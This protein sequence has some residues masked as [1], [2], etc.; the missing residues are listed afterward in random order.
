LLKLSRSEQAKAFAE[1]ALRALAGLAG[2]LKVKY[3]RIAVVLP[4]VWL[5]KE[6]TPMTLAEAIYEHSKKLPED[7]AREVLDFIEFLEQ[8]YATRTEETALI[9]ENRRRAALAQLAGIRIDWGGK[10][11]ADRE[12]LHDHARD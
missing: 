10:P 12:A 1:R 2:A 8:R 9:D 3:W 6:S 11:I 5:D 7:A 4:T